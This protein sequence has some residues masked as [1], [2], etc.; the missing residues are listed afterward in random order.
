MLIVTLNGKPERRAYSIASA[1]SERQHCQITVKRE[2]HGLVS[3]YLHDVVKP[4]DLLP[5][6]GPGGSFTFTGAEANGIVLIAGGVGIT[7]LMSIIRYLTD[8]SW[9]GDILLLYSCR[10]TDEFLF[11]DEL[12][13]L[14]RRHV[15]LKVTAVI[16]QTDGSPW[17]GPRGRL[18]KALI[19]DS[20]S[21]L[22]SRR[23]HVCG[24]APM[25]DAVKGFLGELGVPPGQIRTESFGSPKPRPL[26]GGPIP[27]TEVAPDLAT[28]AARLSPA[29]KPQAS[30]SAKS[31]ALPAATATFAK[32]KKSAPLP[33][34]TPV[35]VAAES[36]GVDI[37]FSCRVGTCGLCKVKLLSGQ[38][39]MAVED[40][41]TPQDKAAGVVLAC[42]AMSEE[43]VAVDA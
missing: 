4:G 8:V 43:D 7:P 13:V 38:V 18:R 9:A 19:A 29:A 20:V 30:A 42:Q 41:L 27:P 23:F 17:M 15:N 39:T 5:A 37:E 40:A 31:A 34:G 35:L 1:P 28:P 2:E 32:S 10:S 24:P 33:H 36:V 16:E 25:M 11:R 14:Q 6:S 12:E 3:P 26:V 21:D 22:P